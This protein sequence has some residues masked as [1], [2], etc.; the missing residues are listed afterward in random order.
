MID[1][2]IVTLVIV[3]YIYV[4]IKKTFFYKLKNLN[5]L[6]RSIL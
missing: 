5:T 4:K 6:E 3:P 1:I 2:I